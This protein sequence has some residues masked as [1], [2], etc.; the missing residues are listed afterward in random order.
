MSQ[1]VAEGISNRPRNML[2]RSFSSALLAEG[3]FDTSSWKKLQSQDVNGQLR[4][5]VELLL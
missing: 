1:R 5:S 3:Q 4:S 2:S